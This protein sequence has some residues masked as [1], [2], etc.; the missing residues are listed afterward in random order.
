[1]DVPFAVAGGL[2]VLL[3][4]NDI[5]LTVLHPT[6]RGPM[7]MWITR[8]MW[9]ALRRVSPRLVG[10]GSLGLMFS[11]WL[12]GLWL[13]FALVYLPF[14]DW[15]NG[16]AGPWTLGDALYLSGTSLTTVGFGD[17]YATSEALRIVTTLEAASGLAAITASIT[18]LLSLFTVL[19]D[20]RAAAARM[21][22]LRATEVRWATSLALHGGPGEVRELQR[23]VI[24]AEEHLRR[25]PVLFFFDPR[26]HN[27]AMSLLEAASLVCV[28]LR[29]GIRPDRL[30]YAA[31]YGTGLQSSLERV[32]AT[33]RRDFV[34]GPHDVPPIDAADAEQR[35]ATLRGAIAEV[36]AGL[37]RDGP[38]DDELRGFLGRMDHFLHEMATTHRLDAHPLLR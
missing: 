14:G 26:D 16:T 20:L 6:V 3:V 37:P 8:G 19:L 38:P 17:M 25:F 2:L 36:D 23:D 35:L 32:T 29:W 5:A 1:M 13:G 30:P 33:I 27:Y 11:A 28:V 12:G 4:V 22:D 9:R 31:D 24:A 34:D 21:S 15:V 10:P 7:T 18:Y